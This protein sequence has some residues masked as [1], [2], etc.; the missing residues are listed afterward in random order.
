MKM[1]VAVTF[2]GILMHA[3]AEECELMPPA[4]EFDS[5][6]YFSIPL[7]YVTHSRSGTTKQDVCRKYQ[8]TTTSDGTI[9]TVVSGGYTNGDGNPQSDVKCINKPKSGSNGQF[10]VECQVPQE[11]GSPQK[12]EIETSVI[13]T[14]NQNYALLQSCSTSGLD[15]ILV[16]QTN[17]NGVHEGVQKVFN[18]NNW[19]IKEWKSRNSVGC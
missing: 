18:I 19:D 12:V 6:K 11:S 7:V 14:D 8:T 17:P 1:I 15:D 4:A 9:E 3:I 10:I 13:A 5:K 2:L 16:L